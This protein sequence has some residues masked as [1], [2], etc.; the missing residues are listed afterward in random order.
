MI[1]APTAVVRPVHV[2]FVSNPWA[3]ITFT[4]DISESKI[5]FLINR[6]EFD[7]ICQKHPWHKFGAYRETTY[8][9]LSVFFPIEKI[10]RSAATVMQQTSTSSGIF[11]VFGSFASSL[12]GRLALSSCSGKCWLATAIICFEAPQQGY[13]MVW[14]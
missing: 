4:K 2:S 8:C 6:I 5:L 12:S 14:S 11:C 3:R 13:A 10:H 1:V 7:W 9:V